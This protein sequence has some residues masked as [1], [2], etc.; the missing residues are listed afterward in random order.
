MESWMEYLA[1]LSWQ[2][3]TVHPSDF[4]KLQN[5]PTLNSPDELVKIVT[6]P[7]TKQYLKD[8]QH[9]W[10]KQAEKDKKECLTAG[11]ELA[12]PFHKNYPA[13][14]FNM[15]K[16]PAIISWRGTTCWQN[17]FHLSVV[18]SR[19]PYTDTL[20]WM[21]VHLSAFLKNKKDICVTSGGAR[22]VDQKAHTLSLAGEN[23]TLCFLPC[24]INHYYPADLKKWENPIMKKRRCL[25]QRVPTHSLYAKNHSF[26]S[27]TGL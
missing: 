14:F 20:L 17:R 7:A 3:Q 16:P 26:I 9:I 22:G 1:L 27:E 12:W 25:P 18:G 15:E 2:G 11:V 8:Y 13:E 4:K 24:G 5:T 10:W 6:N 19:H 23:P 21:D